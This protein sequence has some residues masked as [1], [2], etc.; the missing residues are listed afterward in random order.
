MTFQQQQSAGPAL[1]TGA[2]SGLGRGLALALAAQGWTVL[3]HG[4]DK[5][6]CDQ[7]VQE[8]RAAGGDAHPYLADLSSL[9][10]TAALAQRVADDRPSLGLLVNNAGVGFGADPG[11]R[12][13][14][15][16]G[17]ELRLAV[18][19]LVPVVLTR[20]LRSPLRAGAAQVVNIGSVG[21]S[22]IDFDN[23]QFTRGYDGTEAY[24]RSKFALATFTF[25][26]AEEYVPDRV[27]VNCVHP[28]TF[29]D[30]GMVRDAGISPSTSVA[31]GVDAVLAVVEAGQGD[32]TGVFFNGAR[33]GRA[34]AEAY[35]TE[36]R[37]RLATL[38]NQLLTRVD[39]LAW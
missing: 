24:M 14:G 39:Q 9:G 37:E 4:R 15:A 18:N 29:M 25:T 36:V 20:M 7:V 30:T 26:I 5:A 2:T 21:Q 38:T 33:P 13:L 8:I 34:H 16:D 3:A 6:R 11:H 12:E 17:Y 1:V 23:P 31:Q 22:P 35:G 10:E 19:Y 28:A 32:T 27:R